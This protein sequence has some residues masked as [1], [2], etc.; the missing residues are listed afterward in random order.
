MAPDVYQAGRSRQELLGLDRWRSMGSSAGRSQPHL[1]VGCRGQK[2]AQCGQSGGV[3]K[4]DLEL[5]SGLEGVWRS[6]LGLY[7]SLPPAPARSRL[8]RT[9]R[10]RSVSGSSSSHR[11]CS[12]P[13]GSIAAAEPT[14]PGRTAGG[15]DNTW[16]LRN[17][18]PA[19]GALLRAPAVPRVIQRS[20]HFRWA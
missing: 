9:R 8:P 11:I 13:A 18:L 17:P 15:R 1:R 14:L 12:R 6:Q 16:R 4:S 2:V 5:L 19:E 7:H 20:S 10:M 3:P